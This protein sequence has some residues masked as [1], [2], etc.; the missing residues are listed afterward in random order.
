LKLCGFSLLAPSS[1]TTSIAVI[2]SEAQF[3]KRRIS[4]W[5]RC[6]GDAD[7]LDSACVNVAQA[8]F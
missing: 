1:S 3:A 2:L 6:F 7:V 5:V 4:P 8:S